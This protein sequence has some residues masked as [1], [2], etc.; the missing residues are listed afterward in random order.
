T[1]EKYGLVERPQIGGTSLA[2]FTH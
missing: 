1:V 2:N